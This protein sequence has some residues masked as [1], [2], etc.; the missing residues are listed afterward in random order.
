MVHDTGACVLEQG[1]ELLAEKAR[2][3]LTG[4]AGAADWATFSQGELLSRGLAL[5]ICVIA[6]AL[7]SLDAQVPVELKADGAG[8]IA[9]MA[10]ASAAPTAIAAPSCSDPAKMLAHDR[11]V[12]FLARYGAAHVHTPKPVI[13]VLP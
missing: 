11:A 12:D 8:H 5:A 13:K 1:S 4:A 3:S 9:P 6:A 7:H 2:A 10:L